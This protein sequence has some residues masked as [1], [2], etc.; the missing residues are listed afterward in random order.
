MTTSTIR[1]DRRLRTGGFSVT[2]LIIGASLSTFVLAG[3]LS[4]YLMLGRS[5]MNAA[6]YSMSEAEIRR[7]VEEF[8]QNVRMASGLTWNSPRSITLTLVAPNAYSGLASPHTN[9]VTYGF[10]EPP[11]NET[12]PFYRLPGTTASSSAR[13]ILVRNVSTL[14]YYRYDRLDNKFNDDGVN[15]DA[16]T[17]RIQI[18]LNVLR[19]GK[20]LVDANTTVVMASNILR[21][22]IVN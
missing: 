7:G 1:I 3:V 19:K 9:K 20:T 4:A 11:L 10:D 13:T 21:N 6:S 5:G 17:K 16:S 8:S 18:S 14:T 2:E 22:K 12:N 15:H